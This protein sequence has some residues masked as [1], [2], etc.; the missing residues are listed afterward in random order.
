MNN[1][2]LFAFHFIF[3]GTL[4]GLYFKFDKNTNHRKL[5][6]FI[7]I[8][9]IIAGWAL[10]CLYF[11]YYKDGDTIQYYL[12]AQK[13]YNKLFPSIKD[14]FSY[15]FLND[16]TKVGYGTTMYPTAFAFYKLMA[17]LYAFCG[18]NY[19]L[20]S[21][22]CS[23]FSAIGTYNLILTIKYLYPKFYMPT[24]LSTLFF[25]TVVL[26]SAGLMRE[27]IVIGAMCF[28]LSMAL[29]FKS[30]VMISWWMYLLIP[31]FLYWVLIFKYYYFMAFVPMLFLII[32]SR[33]QFNK[34]ILMAF[35]VFSFV[36]FI[37]I[38]QKIHL[39]FQLSKIF[40]LVV[41]NH[42]GNIE[43]SYF[44]VK[45]RPINPQNVVLFY[46]L[47]GNANSFLINLPKAIY[48][49]FFLPQ[50]T[51][52]NKVIKIVTG[53]ENTILFFLFLYCSCKLLYKSDYKIL[54]TKE[55]IW[56]M[57]MILP[58]A[59]L[60]PF[61]SPNLGS[62]ARYKIA[63]LPFLSAILIYYSGLCDFLLKLIAS[64]NVLGIKNK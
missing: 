28:L 9:K 25:P 27:P 64:K 4:L 59:I 61:T 62:L 39:N 16:Y 15:A 45:G 12:E 23:L 5:L 46:H 18:K 52:T 30:R 57:V 32:I 58:L 14:Y 29:K 34:F 24:L 22:Y 13:V 7:L 56:C 48:S 44:S 41:A 3:I 31:I 17:P 2:I 55:F 10:G 20:M 36:F 37:F 6:I 21:M 49:G 8:I 50:I 35:S 60:L 33:W 40:P 53:F 43:F 54:I 47:E 63:Y 11:F 38:V 51:D 19:W 26:W 1:A 42:D